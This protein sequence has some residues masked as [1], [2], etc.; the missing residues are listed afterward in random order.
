MRKHFGQEGANNRDHQR[1]VRTMGAVCVSFIILIEIAENSPLKKEGEKAEPVV[2]TLLRE[3]RAGDAPVGK[4]VPSAP[5]L[6]DSLERTSGPQVSLNDHASCSGQI[7]SAQQQVFNQTVSREL[8]TVELDPESVTAAR[9]HIAL[10]PR[11]YS[12]YAGYL[13]RCLFG[14]TS[15]D[16]LVIAGVF[17]RY[18][19]SS[20]VSVALDSF[21][22]KPKRFRMRLQVRAR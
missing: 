2:P 10:F 9:W 20:L 11:S 12:S 19:I 22:R 18:E 7:F 6:N 3:L 1:K 5:P 14:D 17:R 15:P 8:P 4:H 13:C 21:E 16:D